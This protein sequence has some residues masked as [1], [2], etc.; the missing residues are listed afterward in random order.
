MLDAK[1]AA[2]YCMGRRWLM[3]N[4]YQGLIRESAARHGAVGADP[5]H[6][7]AWMRSEH[8][9]LDALSPEAFHREVG[10]ALGYMDEAGP[11]M[12]ARLAETYGLCS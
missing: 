9:T 1:Q 11:E 6:V 10:K 5:A 3:T 12:S 8:G 2:L 7:E 4:G